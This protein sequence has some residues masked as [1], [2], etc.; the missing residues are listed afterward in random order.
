MRIELSIEACFDTVM[1]CLSVYIII[2]KWREQKWHTTQTNRKKKKK[3]RTKLNWGNK[4]PH[5]HFA[6]ASRQSMN[7]HMAKSFN[8]NRDFLFVVASKERGNRLRILICLWKFHV[9]MNSLQ[10]HIFVSTLV[11]C[12]TFFSHVPL[13]RHRLHFFIYTFCRDSYSLCLS[14]SVHIFCAQSFR[15][16]SIFLRTRARIKAKE[17]RKYTTR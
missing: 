10:T 15:M 12:G 14:H 8:K 11:L 3:C 9:F 17:I 4:W 16:R 2:D 7:L 1:S 6:T 13:A 5:K